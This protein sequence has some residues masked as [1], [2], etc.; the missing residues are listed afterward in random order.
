MCNAV[1]PRESR[2]NFQPQAHGDIQLLTLLD[3]LDETKQQTADA[4][5]AHCL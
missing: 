4:R 3:S 1:S 2:G 5:D